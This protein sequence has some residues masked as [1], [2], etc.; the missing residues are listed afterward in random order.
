M[1]YG[2]LLC[3]VCGQLWRELP[4][5]FVPNCK[6]PP[7]VQKGGYNYQ[8]AVLSPPLIQREHL[9]HMS[10]SQIRL[11]HLYLEQASVSREL[12]NLPETIGHY[13]KAIDI[14]KKLAEEEPAV[15]ELVADTIERVGATY[16]AAGELE[17]A[18]ETL[19]EAASL[20]EALARRAATSED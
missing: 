9:P 13:T 14:Y 4:A 1:T 2:P 19:A 6:C 7:A 10:Q 5:L 15:Y 20:R 16:K 12:G 18:K 11:A 3:W 17:K 8:Q